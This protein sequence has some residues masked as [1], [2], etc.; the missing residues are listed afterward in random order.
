MP[1]FDNLGLGQVLQWGNNPDAGS[2]NARFGGQVGHLLKGPDVLRAAVGISAVI[3]GIDT[4]KDMPGPRAFPP[5]A[6]AYEKKNGIS[7]RHIRYRDARRHVGRLARLGNVDAR[8]GQG[9]AADL[10][11]IDIDNHMPGRFQRSRHPFGGIEFLRMTLAVKKN[12]NCIFQS[13]PDGQWP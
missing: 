6:S 5:Q 10:L 9:R 4:D 13:P 11:Q 12:S 7:R 8:I 1:I 2:F 3:E